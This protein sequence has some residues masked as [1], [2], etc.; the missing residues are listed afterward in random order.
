M[1]RTP[2]SMS[3]MFFADLRAPDLRFGAMRMNTLV[4]HDM[5]RCLFTRWAWKH[6]RGT[7]KC[8]SVQY[9]KSMYGCGQTVPQINVWLRC[10][11]TPQHRDACDARGL[12]TE[13]Q[14]TTCRELLDVDAIT[15]DQTQAPQ[16]LVV[17]IAGDVV[18]K[19][20]MHAAMQAMESNVLRTKLRT[21]C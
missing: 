5:N 10:R 21:T 2:T 1:L 17:S 7:L 11:D 4:W 16:I 18:H 3:V 15:W 9:L 12:G 8:A 6:Q 13:T 14:T 20:A 19:V